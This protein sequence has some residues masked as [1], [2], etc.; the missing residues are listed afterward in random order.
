MEIT[1]GKLNGYFIDSTNVWGTQHPFDILTNATEVEFKD[2]LNGYLSEN[3]SQDGP[4]FSVQRFSNYVIKNGF[5]IKTKGNFILPTVCTC[6]ID[7][8][9]Y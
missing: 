1:M 9:Y 4:D 3:E 8:F 7:Y 6:K 2:L 5:Y